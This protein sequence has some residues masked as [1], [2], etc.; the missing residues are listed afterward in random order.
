[1]IMRSQQLERADN[2]RLLR[3]ADAEANVS[4][5]G[6]LSSPRPVA[7]VHLNMP[8]DGK[9]EIDSRK[10]V[11]VFETD[12]QIEAKIADAVSVAETESPEAAV[13]RLL[14]LER[15]NR[16]AA[17]GPE[18]SAVCVAVIRVFSNLKDWK[19]VGEHVVLLSKRRAQLKA[20]VTKTVQEAMT[21]L[22][23]VTDDADRLTL[24]ETLRDVTAGKIYVELEGARLSRRLAK[25]KEDKGDV[26]AAAE[27]MQELQIETFGGMERSEKFDFIL[28]QMRLCLEKNDFIRGA[29]IAKKIIPRQLNKDEF[30]QEKL[31]FYSLM[32][33][34]HARNRDYMGICR[35]YLERYETAT[36]KADEALWSRELRLA[37]LFLILSPRDSMQSDMLHRVRAYKDM[38]KLDTYGDLLKMFATDELIGWPHLVERFGAEL[39]SVVSLAAMEAKTE[40]VDWKIALKERCTEHN[41]RVVSKYYTRIRLHRLAELLDQTEDDT[42]RKLAA[43]VADKKALWAKIDRPAKIVSFAKPKNADTTLNAWATNVTSLL[44]IVERTCH[45]VGRE[46]MV[47]NV[48]S[49]NIESL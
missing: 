1:M 18:T 22:D 14:S 28:E 12:P 48:K 33:R 9:M 26:E 47:H 27:I 35:A 16:M 24:L 36:C 49:T 45:L 3:I 11:T 13:E 7:H 25:L 30:D 2:H 43:M 19:A 31:R 41:L 38:S 15:V 46:M 32:I 17:A 5:H 34:I 23:V 40:D 8:N 4:S 10:E 21:Y 42:E 6:R 37:S 44:D 39:T 20:A 29:I